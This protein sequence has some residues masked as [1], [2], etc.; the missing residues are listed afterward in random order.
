[1]LQPEDVQRFLWNNHWRT[2]YPLGTVPQNSTRLACQLRVFLK[3]HHVDTVISTTSGAEPQRIRALFERALGQPSGITVPS[4]SGTGCRMMSGAAVFPV[5]HDRPA[6]RGRISI[7]CRSDFLSRPPVPSSPGGAVV[8]AHRRRTTIGPAKPHFRE[9]HLP[10]GEGNRAPDLRRRARGSRGRLLQRP[11]GR[12]RWCHGSGAQVSWPTR[13]R[14]QLSCL[15][16]ALFPEPSGLV[17]S[18]ILLVD[19]AIEDPIADATVDR[20]RTPLSLADLGDGR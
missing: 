15:I 12:P 20:P 4:T 13:A 2:P 8:R 7:Q 14:R 19:E 10:Q 18:R 5:P 3:T 16:S 1:V 17:R 9:E 6:W 11:D